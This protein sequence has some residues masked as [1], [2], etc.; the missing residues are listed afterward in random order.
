MRLVDTQPREILSDNG[1]HFAL[2][3]MSNS[4]QQPHPGVFVEVHSS[5]CQYNVVRIIV[6][7]RTVSRKEQCRIG[8]QIWSGQSF[9]SMLTS[10]GPSE[11]GWLFL[12]MGNHPHPTFNGI[13]MFLAGRT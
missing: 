1:F 9:T 12:H 7:T 6:T 11:A 5:M 10:G 8:Y 3:K 4:K 13:K 2:T